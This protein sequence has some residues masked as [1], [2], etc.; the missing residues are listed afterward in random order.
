MAFVG[1]LFAQEVA[2]RRVATYA[3]SQ[4]DTVTNRST[5]PQRRRVDFMAD[6]VRPY[7]Q[8]ADSIVY[9]V[10]NF[11]AHHNGAVISCDSSVRYSDTHWGFFGRLLINQDS[12]YIYGDSALYDGEVG[13]AEIYAPIVKVVDGDAL[14]YTYNFKFNTESR[15]GNYT[16]G[17]VL[18]HD[19]NIIESQRG[20]YYSQSHD[21]ICVEDVELHGAEYDMKSDSIIYNTDSEM[22]HFFS[23]SEIWNADGDY[24][25]ADAGLYDKAQDLYMVTRNGYIL[26]ADQELWGDTLSYY[27]TRGYIEGRG[28]IQMDD[29][30]EKMMAFADYAEY[31]NTEG[32]MLLTR[33]PSV[34][35]YDLSRSDSI[36]MRADTIMLRT[37]SVLEER[38]EAER[39]AQAKEEAAEAERQAEQAERSTVSSAAPSNGA[40]APRN[41]ERSNEFRAMMEADSD[42]A[43]EVEEPLLQDELQQDSLMQDSIQK[44]SVVLSLKEQRAVAKTAAKEQ[45]R[46]LKEEARKVKMAERKVKLDS[47]ARI[48]QAK[49][50]AMLDRQ[51]AKE[52]ARAERDSVRRAERRAKLVGKGRDVS[53]LDREDSL[54]G[55]E[56][57]RLRRGNLRPEMNDSLQREFAEAPEA[58]SMTTMETVD[59]I[60]ADSVYRLLKAYRNVKMWRKDAQMVCD[61][62]AS[63][64]IDS[65]VRLYIDPVLWNGSNQL[66]ATEMQLYTRNQQL[67]RA[68]FLEDPIMV[69]EVDGRYFNQVTGKKMTAFFRDN[70]LYRDDVEGN[71]Q[72]IYFRTADEQSKEV[73]EMTYLESASA[74][75]YL[76]DQQLVGITYRN[77]V[78]FTLYPIGLV[79]P[80]QPTELP[81]FKW[82]PE[83]RPALE[84]VFDREL[85]PSRRDAVQFAP[86]PVFRIVERMDRRK[87][88]L[89]QAG[90]WYDRE[91]EL[92]PEVQQWR[93]TR[94]L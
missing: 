7:S 27:R 6:I 69:G 88:A 40:A 41:A 51:K 70:A 49:V 5:T 44:D 54:A 67:E 37:I 60:A 23:S 31:W 56:R 75:F 83:R 86:R 15:I 12:I 9:L 34:M 20:Y 72:T 59:S 33:R 85:R 81:N 92:S 84:D 17:G 26:T 78:P 29:R 47:I 18:V 4:A 80:T 74:S 76:E 28:N 89:M 62:L 3:T 79:P 25:S 52:L 58:D 82:V 94:G 42:M 36:F 38:R 46:K 14:L 68:E 2:V 87:E 21:I 1:I 65:I 53:A 10:G 39:E 57:E 48:R 43:G 73:I 8:G 22:A 71:V 13:M 45:A 91:D 32:N 90:D 50:T 63:S 35:S 66:A 55:V 64:T 61:S 24:L 77:E 30:K 93:D 11:A 19:D 16:G